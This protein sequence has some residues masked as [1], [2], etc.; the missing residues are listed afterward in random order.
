[1]KTQGH[2]MEPLDHCFQQ[3]IMNAQPRLPGQPIG[4][5][6]GDFTEDAEAQQADNADEQHPRLRARGQ[7]IKHILEDER[8]GGVDCCQGQRNEQDASDRAPIRQGKPHRSAQPAQAGRGA[9][10]NWFARVFGQEQIVCPKI[11]NQ[12]QGEP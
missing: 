11:S 5:G 10:L 3:R 7:A 2:A 8:L 6:A 12:W 1:M 4:E 9:A